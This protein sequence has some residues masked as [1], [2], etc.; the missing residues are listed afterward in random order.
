MSGPDST[1]ETNDQ[2]QDQTKFKPPPNLWFP[3]CTPEIMWATQGS[4]PSTAP[5]NSIHVDTMLQ[6]SQ[7]CGHPRSNPESPTSPSRAGPRRIGSPAYIHIPTHAYIFTCCII[8]KSV[9]PMYFLI[10]SISFH[11][12][13]YKPVLV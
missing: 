13:V 8:T 6:I 1:K 11:W 3:I 12:L 9:Y 5:K 10:L 4:H 7:Q 2:D